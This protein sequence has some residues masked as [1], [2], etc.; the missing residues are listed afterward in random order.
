MRRVALSPLAQNDVQ[1][2]E[3]TN[4]VR[5]SSK[6]NTLTIHAS[7]DAEIQMSQVKSNFFGDMREV[8][9]V[10]FIVKSAEDFTQT[11]SL[12]FS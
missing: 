9:C 11:F 7:V 3:V 6:E 12:S 4:E 2:D 8:P 10:D 5:I 1:T